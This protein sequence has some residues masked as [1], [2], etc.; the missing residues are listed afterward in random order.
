LLFFYV[1]DAL[2]G[3]ISQREMLKFIKY[4]GA[5]CKTQAQT[6]YWVDLLYVGMPRRTQALFGFMA[7]NY[8]KLIRA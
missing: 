2:S 7:S 4:S 8:E 1:L 3:L 5:W 6:P